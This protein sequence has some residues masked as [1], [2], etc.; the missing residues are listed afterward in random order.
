[1]ID[2]RH[3]DPDQRE[4]LYERHEALIREVASRRGNELSLTINKDLAPRPCDQGIVDTISDAAHA[5]S[6]PHMRMASGAVHDAQR[7]AQIARTAMIFVQ[8]KDGR[9]HTPEEYTST[10]HAT[11]GI[12]LLAESL[13]RLAYV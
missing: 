6:I 1:M 9:S 11:M 10:E 12:E 7:F 8:S 4:L 5:L 2:A 13:R 3:P